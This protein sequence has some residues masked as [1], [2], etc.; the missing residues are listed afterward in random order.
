MPPSEILP[1]VYVGDQITAQSSSFFEIAKIHTVINCTQTIPF[2]FEARGARYFRVP[3][4]DTNSPED[5][6]V[7]A[8][9]LPQVLEIVRQMQPSRDR[10][11]LVH[12]AA[13]VSRSCTVAA[14]IVRDC[15]AESIPQAVS[16][17][18]SRRPIA[19]FSGRWLN[20]YHALK[21]VFKV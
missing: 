8:A 2:Y 20:F 6:V 9:A 10:G 3:V 15:C 4:N 1:G 21:T 14:A 11:L 18:V 12:C 17:V 13:G 19:F 7:M 5:N 16:M